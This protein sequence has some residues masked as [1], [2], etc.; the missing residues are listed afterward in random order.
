MPPFSVV[1]LAASFCHWYPGVDAVTN[2]HDHRTQ[3]TPI[4]FKLI[5]CLALIC[6][7][8]QQEKWI[9]D[10]CLEATQI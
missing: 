2:H 3:G 9:F 10:V 1:A 4:R 8:W 7:V 5:S 6:D